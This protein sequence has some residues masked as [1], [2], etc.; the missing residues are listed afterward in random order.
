M[1]QSQSGIVLYCCMLFNMLALR[2]FQSS[3][4]DVC[5]RTR[6]D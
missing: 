5:R 6:H 4:P 1:T 3:N 2:R